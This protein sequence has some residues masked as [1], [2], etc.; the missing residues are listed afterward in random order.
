MQ[1]ERF[2]AAVENGEQRKLRANFNLSAMTRTVTNRLEPD[3]APDG[4]E[5]PRAGFG[6]VAGVI[7]HGLATLVVCW[8]D[9]LTEVASRSLSA[10]SRRLQG[11]CN[12]SRTRRSRRPVGKWAGNRQDR[13]KG[14]RM[15]SIRRQDRRCIAK[16][17]KDNTQIP[18][19]QCHWDAST[20]PVLSPKRHSDH[21]TGTEQIRS[22]ECLSEQEAELRC[23]SA[24]T[25]LT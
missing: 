13:T 21:M 10:I 25:D 23:S 1:L 20:P 11:K 2:S 24:A 5:P 17:D 8:S 4:R 22:P 19:G 16:S 7:F 15:P 12:S 14:N 9:A 18:P 6:N 3:R